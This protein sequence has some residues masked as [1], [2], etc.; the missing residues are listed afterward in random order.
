MAATVA[1]LREVLFSVESPKLLVNRQTGM[2]LLTEDLHRRMLKATTQE[3]GNAIVE[4]AKKIM[5]M[6]RLCYV[7]L[8]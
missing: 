4:D 6:A 2:P 7:R 3:E 5:V 8:G 1:S